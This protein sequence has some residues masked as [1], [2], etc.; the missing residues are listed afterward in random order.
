MESFGQL[1]HTLIGFDPKQG[2]I[3]SS[4]PI[5]THEEKANK[6][7]P[8]SKQEVTTKKII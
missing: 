4:Y 3:R 8:Q 2:K 7:N 1:E 5:I 6:T